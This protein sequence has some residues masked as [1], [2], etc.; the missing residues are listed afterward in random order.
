MSDP[1]KIYDGR[2]WSESAPSQK[3]YWSVPANHETWNDSDCITFFLIPRR[4]WSIK[5]WKFANSVRAEMLEIV[6][7]DWKKKLFERCK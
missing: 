4:W 5:S 1:I 6:M 2:A 7:I 3:V